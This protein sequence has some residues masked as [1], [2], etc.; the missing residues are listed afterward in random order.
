MIHASRNRRNCENDAQKVDPA[1]VSSSMNSKRQNLLPC[2]C[3]IQAICTW[4]CV[5]R[6]LRHSNLIEISVE[7]RF[8]FQNPE[9]IPLV[10]MQKGDCKLSAFDAFVSVHLSAARDWADI[11]AKKTASKV[12]L[13]H[14]ERNP[15]RSGN[16]YT[17]RS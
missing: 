13:M 10:C 12:N 16:H 11:F 4:L 3:P 15:T 14:H 7:H 5:A 8:F 17:P 1:N 9:A 6:N 2:H